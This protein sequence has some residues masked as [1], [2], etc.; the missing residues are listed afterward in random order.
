MFKKLFVS[1]GMVY[2][3][4]GKAEYGTEHVASLTVSVD[5]PK[6]DALKL[7]HTFAASPELL[8]GVKTMLLY[9]E[10]YGG[11]VTSN[12]AGPN[13]ENIKYYRDLIAK[14]GGKV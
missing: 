11:E 4:N 14:A 9:I 12:F 8:E 2:L 13:N 3:D 7:A 6:A 1:S 10:T 5:L